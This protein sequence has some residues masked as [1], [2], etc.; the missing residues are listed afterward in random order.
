MNRDTNFYLPDQALANRN[1]FLNNTPTDINTQYYSLAAPVAN[2]PAH[3]NSSAPNNTPTNINMQ[4]HPLA[5]PVPNT[6]TPTH[7]NSS[8][9]NSNTLTDTNSSTNQNKGTTTNKSRK[10]KSD[11]VDLVLP[12]GSR[13]IRKKKSRPDENV[14]VSTKR[15]KKK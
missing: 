4:Y 3:T 10:R 9:L 14:P 13:R 12:D 11:D 2:T 5:A 1:I 15:G 6:D 7:A 8:A